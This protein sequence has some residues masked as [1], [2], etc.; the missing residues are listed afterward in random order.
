ME[1]GQEEKKFPSHPFRKGGDSIGRVSVFLQPAEKTNQFY[2][3]EVA[4][5]SV[6]EFGVGNRKLNPFSSHLLPW[7]N[8]IGINVSFFVEF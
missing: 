5:E 8:L 2:I 7:L 1:N 3:D 6:G 4:V